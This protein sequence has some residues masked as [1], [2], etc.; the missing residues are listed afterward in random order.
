MKVAN[1]LLAAQLDINRHLLE[2]VEE[3]AS[4]N[5]EMRL[6]VQDVKHAADYF[7]RY[8]DDLEY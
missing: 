5:E 8:K 2:F 1:Q 4:D 6:K 7:Q 3:L